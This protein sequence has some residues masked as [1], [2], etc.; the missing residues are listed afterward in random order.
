M[1]SALFIVLMATLNAF[2]DAFE[3]ENYGESVLKNW[4]R[5]FYYKRESWKTAKRIFGYKIDGWHLTKSAMIICALFAVVLYKP[6]IN[7]W[8]DMLLFGLI[9]NVTFTLVYHKILRIK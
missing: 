6:I 8:M 7:K 9:W 4:T 1:T 3:N 2:M 5:S